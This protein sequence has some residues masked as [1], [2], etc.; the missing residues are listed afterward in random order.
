M[1]K[2]LALT[3]L[4]ATTACVP[5]LTTVAIYKGS[6]AANLAT[7]GGEI[8][9]LTENAYSRC[10]AGTGGCIESG[11]YT[12]AFFPV[13]VAAALAVGKPELIGS[14]GATWRYLDTQIPTISTVRNNYG[15]KNYWAFMEGK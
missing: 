1:R 3:A 15:G 5:A 9:T 6:Q 11:I 12:V 2:L 10:Q 8:E 13:D 14:H 7:N 4:L